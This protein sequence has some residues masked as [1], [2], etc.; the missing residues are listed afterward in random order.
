MASINS[1][2]SSIST[3][4]CFSSDEE[5][6]VSDSSTS[7]GTF[8]HSPQD[9]TSSSQ[10]S[11]NPAEQP[12]SIEDRNRIKQLSSDLKSK[13]DKVEKQRAIIKEQSLYIEELKSQKDISNKKHQALKIKNMEL[14][15]TTSDE[16]TKYKS[17]IAELND[18][19][20]FL[21][22]KVKKIMREKESLKRIAEESPTLML[23]TREPRSSTSS[24][25]SQRFHSLSTIDSFISGSLTSINEMEEL[26]SEMSKKDAVIHNKLDQIVQMCEGLQQPLSSQL[27]RKWQ[28]DIR[29]VHHNNNDSS[30]VHSQ[31]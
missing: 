16:I 23:P 30:F 4:T 26:R 12:S 24:S 14:Q 2:T 10:D 31:T 13:S 28:S 27:R 11:Y 18:E 5:R 15:L 17:K 8:N 7:S 3:A 29:L 25:R 19:I 20:R 6:Y 1:H 21:H 9:L 22:Q